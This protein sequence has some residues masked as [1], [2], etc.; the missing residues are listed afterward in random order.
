[1]YP[2]IGHQLVAFFRITG[3]AGVT[4]VR[5]SG[6]ATWKI[7]RDQSCA[8]VL[9]DEVVS[10]RHAMVQFT[11]NDEYY[12]IDLGSRNGTF[13]NEARVSTPCVLADG[14]Q[15]SIGAFQLEFRCD[16]S[17]RRIEAAV[18]SG[19][20]SVTKAIYAPRLVSVLVVDVRGYTMLAQTIE[21]A[22]LCQLIG[23]WFREAGQI[24]E[25]HGSWGLKYIGDAVMTVWL[26][27]RPAERRKQIVR[28]LRAYCDFARI[29]A[30]LQQQFDLPIPFL[31]G[32]GLNT[33]IATVGNT[34]TGSNTDFTALGE[35]VN[36]AFRIESSTRQMGCDLAIGRATW[37][38]LGSP[39]ECFQERLV[40]LKGYERATRVWAGSFQ[41]VE[42]LLES[43]E[44]EAGKQE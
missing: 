20:V 28:I 37:E 14:D 19:D 17:G 35:V 5:L 10:R 34:G 15:I 33:G 39:A 6:G 16:S 30:G 22:L 1:M 38:A 29:T 26:H 11:E 32:A 7:G 24:M 13:L 9:Q 40:E 36:A 42:G 12:L 23:S 8:V 3:S 43:A 31:I 4:E 2:D 41:A 27:D 44:R 21:N 25:A 18:D